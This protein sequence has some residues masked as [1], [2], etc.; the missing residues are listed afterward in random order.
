MSK[1]PPDT[2]WEV[3][4]GRALEGASLHEAAEFWDGRYGEVYSSRLEETDELG[5]HG[6]IAE[7]LVR[8]AGHGRVQAR[9][10]DVGCGTGILARLLDERRFSYLGLDPSAAALDQAR[11][12]AQAAARPGA[13]FRQARFGDLGEGERFSAVVLNEVLYYLD[14]PAALAR[15]AEMLEGPR[16]LVISLYD[17]PYGRQLLDEVVAGWRPLVRLGLENPGRG[18]KWTVLAGVWGG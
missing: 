18:H 14:P 17:F 10:L 13:E 1:L 7:V 9:V 4:Q 3:V 5:R 16:L 15:V 12:A 2:P 6:I 11:A 8:Q